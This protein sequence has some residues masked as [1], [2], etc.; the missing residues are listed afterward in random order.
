ER[1]IAQTMEFVERFRAKASKARQAQS[2]LRMV[3]RKQEQM[4]ELPT[5]SRRYPKFRLQ[6]QRHS[7]RDVLKV[8]GVSKTYGERQVLNGVDLV[9]RRGDRLA[10]M[11]P[12]GIGK[13][14]LLRIAM[15]ETPADGT[16]E[17]GYET[18]P[19]YFEQDHHE[20]LETLDLTAEQWVSQFCPDKGVGYV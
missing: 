13:S 9:V 7:G 16:V 1:E 11:G 12:N 3:E 4:E 6:E 20:S 8:S 2:K 19:G 18:Y 17:W 15:G 5:S 10:I 14:T